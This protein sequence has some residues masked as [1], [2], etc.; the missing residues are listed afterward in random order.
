MEKIQNAYIAHLDPQSQYAP[1]KLR[2]HLQN[3]ADLARAFAPLPILK[4]MAYQC[5]LYHDVGKFAVK[6]QNYIRGKYHGRVDH[7]T[8]G[9]QLLVK[10]RTLASIYEAICIAGHHTGLLD[11]GNRIAEGEDGTFCDRLKKKIPDYSSYK[12]EMG[13]PMKIEVEQKN[14]ADPSHFVFNTLLIRMLFSALVDADFLDTETYMNHGI[15]RRG[16]FSSVEELNKRFFTQLEQ[17]GFFQ[18]TNFLNQKR[19][20]ILKECIQAGNEN[21]GLYSLTV[22]T[23]GGKTIASMAF[24]LEHATKYNKQ[25]IIYVIPYT[26]IIEQNAEVFRSFLGENDVIEHHSQVEYN[27]KEEREDPRK[28]ATENWDAPIIVTTNVQFF[29]SLFANRTSKCR[30]LHNIANSV[31]IFDEVQMLPVEYMKPVLQGI[32]CLVRNFGCTAVLCSATQPNLKRIENGLEE[33]PVEIINDVQSL[34]PVFRRTVLQQDGIMTY[35]EVAGRIDQNPQCLCICL[36]KGEAGKIY[37]AVSE[38]C[39]YLSTNLC[40]AHRSVVIA[41]MKERLKTGLPCRVVSTSIISVGV[42]IDFPVVY[43]EEAGLDA[44]IQGAGRCNRENHRSAEESIVHIFATKEEQASR[45]MKQERQCT[46]VVMRN[47]E[48]ITSPAAIADY[49]E[50][51]YESKE[52]ILDQKE[53]LKLSQNMSFAQ[54]GREFHLIEDHTKSLLIP[55]NA[56][57]EKIIEALQKGIFTRELLRKAGKYTVAVWSQ[58][59]GTPGLY[60]QILADGDAEAINGE[61]AILTN[62]ELYD[63]HMGL[64]YQKE[65]GRGIFI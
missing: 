18:P 14:L 42:D 13:E 33:E 27:D 16:N 62:R 35:A 65:E 7:S 3:V 40:P 5:G 41:A 36:T 53:I 21:P 44:L 12:T 38:P 1:Q 19:T 2:D 22:P 11:L 4:D 51:L 58:A 45:F 57:A 43:L 54:I 9:A 17:R 31:I 30:K 8:A 15:I 25:R 52:S 23:G 34:Y 6:F 28:L 26:S 37:E 29:E 50:R 24:A 63:E 55:W 56:E 64:H 61:M 49:F 10:N 39:F 59:K 20:E 60:E 46:G 48:D 47:Y 32:Q